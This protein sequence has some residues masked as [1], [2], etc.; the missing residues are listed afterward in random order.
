MD[1]REET[2]WSISGVSDF[3]KG[4][5]KMEE[6]RSDWMLSMTSV[7]LEARE[8][9]AATQGAALPLLP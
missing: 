3:L 2:L 5:K 8:P 1:K 9:V 7:V 6:I 4:K